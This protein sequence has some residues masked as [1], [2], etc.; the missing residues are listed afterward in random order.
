MNRRQML[1]LA[2]GGLGQTALAALLGGRAAAA[3]GVHF[4]ARARRVVW[5]FMAGAPSQLDLF[6]Y[7]PGLAARFDEDLPD[8]VRKGQRLG[9]SSGQARFPVAPSLFSFAQH[10]QSGTWVSDLL[11]WTAKLVDEIA[12]IRSLQTEAINHEPA[13]MFINSGSEVGGKP[14]LGAWLS[15]GLGSNNDNLPTF[16]VMTSRYT[17]KMNVQALSARMW[18]S[19]FLPAEHGGVTVRGGA[20]PMLYLR[21]PAGVDGGSRRAM[22]DGVRSM[23]EIHQRA[24][25]DRQT[26]DRI[27]Q[28]EMAFRMQSAVPE[29]ADVSGETAATRALYGQDVDL[30]GT[31]AANC[32]TARRL[33]ER[34]VRFVQIYHRGWDSHQQLPLRHAAQCRDVDRACYGFV[35]DLKSRGLLDDTLVIWGGEFGRTVYS[36][37]A[38]TR[39]DYGRD[40]HPRCFTIWMAGAGIKP[41][42]VFG[43]TDDYSYN[44]VRD[45]V[46]LRDLHATILHLSGLDHQRLSVRHQGLDQRL[47]AVGYPARVVNELLA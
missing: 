39:N 47:I 40:H 19:G 14:S 13:T 24:M 11:P 31:F 41:G 17:Q 5:L 4:P 44:V 45:P 46:H 21:N 34:G 9:M 25:G 2:G 27:A 23:N 22:L 30:P 36:Q 20:D 10:G 1:A 43:E 42:I 26:S 37:G 35:T 16:A 12:V 38:L 32:L 6:D 28:Y 8:S 15:Y 33:L 29:L 7:K 3:P 18:S